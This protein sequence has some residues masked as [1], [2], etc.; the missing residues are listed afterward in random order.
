[1]LKCKSNALKIN[2]GLRMLQYLVTLTFTLSLCSC[3]LVCV[4]VYPPPLHARTHTRTHTHTHTHIHT[5]THTHTDAIPTS[6]SEDDSFLHPSEQ[7][8][9]VGETAA[10]T[11]KTG[12]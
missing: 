1:M 12:L 9:S 8:E 4:P 2:N 11:Q 10:G 7:C 5:H 6:H 3:V